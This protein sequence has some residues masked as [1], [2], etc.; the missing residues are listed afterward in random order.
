MKQEF[1]PKDG[2]ICY[3]NN[4]CVEIIFIY[5]KVLE[6]NKIYYYSS[7][8]SRNYLD[9]G[10]DWM[11]S[12]GNLRLATKEEKRKLFDELEKQ[13]KRWNPETKQI[14]DILKVGDICIFWDDDKK[15]AVVAK[16]LNINEFSEDLKTSGYDNPSSI[17]DEEG[18]NLCYKNAIKC[19][20]LQHYIDFMNS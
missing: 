2:D 9:I 11:D 16:L 6:G 3:S 19:E 7:I 20:S 5:K 10:I 17:L 12:N 18:G 13:S 8:N 15:D 1:K 4:G 14:E